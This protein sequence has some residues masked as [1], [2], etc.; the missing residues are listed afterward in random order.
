MFL[1]VPISFADDG[2]Y[3]IPSAVKDIMVQDDGSTIITEE[4]VYDIEGRVNGVYRDIPH[5]RNQTI[6]DISV[7][8]P[9][10]YNTLEVIEYN[11]GT[12]IKVW[13]YEDEAKTSKTYDAK[14]AVTYKYTFN[15]GVKIYNDIAELQYMTWGDE[16]DVGVK[17]LESNI[18]IPG[19]KD[20][21]EYWNNPD[22]Y[23]VSSEWTDDNTL[24]T[25]SEGL[26]SR[27]SYEQRI[28]MPTSYFKSTENAQVI[29]M[30]AKE[31]IEADQ[32]KYQE[33]RNFHNMIISALT[34][35]LGILMIVPLGI[36]GLFGRE[37]KIDY[38]AEYE[39]DLPTDATPIQVNS[40]VIGDVDNIDNNG[41]YATILDL[42]NKKY[43]KVISSNEDDTIIRQTDKDTSNLKAY[44]QS[45]LSYLSKF[46]VNNDISLK[47]IGDT[48]DP[49][50]YK[51]FKSSWESK[52]KEEVPDEL[53]KRYFDK[54]GSTIF[55]LV[56]G[57]FSVI[58]I[59]MFFVSVYLDMPTSRFLVL[60]GLA[61]LLFVESII[62]FCI[63]NT[64]AG[65]W[66]PEGK[67]FHDKWKS[68]ENYL[69]DF[70]LIK[71]RPP[72][73]IE[74]WGKYLVYAA[75]LGCADEVSKNM[76][77]YFD[78]KG[79][80][81]SFFTSS[82]AVYFAY[83]GGFSHMNTSFSSLTASSSDSGGIGS[84]GGGGFGGGGGGTF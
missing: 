14:V 59:I 69:T 49:E 39:Y 60:F 44:E 1:L 58:S 33:D 12:R 75:A 62:M 72:A 30:D 41:L 70:S 73:S 68:F 53:I 57:L 15:N 48:E 46:T 24:T 37:P 63:P 52:A 21:T 43:L 78:L 36:Y 32:K 6:T 77:K 54:K 3:S 10:Y 76:K 22:D 40:I 5:S 67:E 56:A 28:L 47:S 19:S 18:H 25:I 42:I 8:T 66:T 31:K 17:H 50:K 80:S 34:W 51:S 38:D 74:V 20:N 35:I 26:G 81:E 83:Y 45:L 4:I 84:V 13:L 2:D 71:E 55:M 23:V 29:N 79:L 27:T 16:W 9:G 61:I 7:D 82:D 11:G 65:K 64:F